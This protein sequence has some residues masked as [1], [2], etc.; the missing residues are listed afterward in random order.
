MQTDV[1]LINID[2]EDGK[3]LNGE[4]DD[5]DELSNLY[6]KFPFLRLNATKILR[7]RLPNSWLRT[8]TKW[9]LRGDSVG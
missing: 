6:R 2:S 5:E 1:P 4:I 8:W 9:S 3:A 7:Y